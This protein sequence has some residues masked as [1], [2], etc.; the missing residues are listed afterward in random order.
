[1]DLDD[2]RHGAWLRFKPVPEE[3]LILIK[4]GSVDLK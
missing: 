2:I 4:I 3:N 1:M